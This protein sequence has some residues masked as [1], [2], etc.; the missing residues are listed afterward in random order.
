MQGAAD[1]FTAFN[2]AA[3]YVRIVKSEPGDVYRYNV[4]G[5]DGKTRSRGNQIGFVLDR[6]EYWESWYAA[7]VD[8][9]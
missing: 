1:A 6:A 2:E 9:A 3:Q 4:I 8:V 5:I 7:K